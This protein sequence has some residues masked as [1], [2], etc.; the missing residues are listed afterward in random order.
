MGRAEERIFRINDE[1]AALDRE[2]ELVAAELEYHRHI[3]D[4]AER[5]AVV[6][7]LQA[8]ALEAGATRADVKRFERRLEQ[9]RTR[10]ERLAAKRERLI[11][12][13]G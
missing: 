10:R 2:E 7:G 4:D 12:K 3:A 11:G 13:L 6:S 8:D 9:I 1:L 5:D